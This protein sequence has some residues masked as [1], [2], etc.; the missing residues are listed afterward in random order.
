MNDTVAYVGIAFFAALIIGTL[1][2]GMR[3]RARADAIG[4]LMIACRHAGDVLPEQVINGD[5]VV[6]TRQAI[7]ASVSVSLKG[8][9]HKGKRTGNR[10]PAYNQQVVLTAHQSLEGNVPYRFPF[11]LQI[12]SRLEVADP[13]ERQQLE[14]GRSDSGFFNTTYTMRWELDAELESSSGKIECRRSL[15]WYVA[16]IEEGVAKEAGASNRR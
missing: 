8:F 13:R 6:T 1:L 14:S 11:S 16:Y 7:D 15:G 9:R 5:I 3:A 4:E 12:P 2:S 10:R